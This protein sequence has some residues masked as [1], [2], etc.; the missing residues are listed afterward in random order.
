MNPSEVKYKAN[1]IGQGRIRQLNQ[2]E[3]ST[4]AAVTHHWPQ[5]AEV[6]GRELAQDD[7][8]RQLNFLR[9]ITNL[10]LELNIGPRRGNADE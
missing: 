1:K 10:N 8:V 3:E 9:P 6:G 5:E 4:V 2:L 7:Q